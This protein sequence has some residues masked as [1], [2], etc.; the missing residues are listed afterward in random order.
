[1]RRWLHRTPFLLALLYCAAVPALW[2]RSFAHH[3]T[4]GRAWNSD[5]DGLW[6]EHRAELTSAGGIVQ[7]KRSATVKYKDSDDHL[8]RRDW[9][10]REFYVEHAPFDPLIDAGP[11]LRTIDA[12]SIGST[13]LRGDG[14]VV[15]GGWMT[16]ASGPVWLLLVPG[17]LVAAFTLGLAFGA[18]QPWRWR[19]A[20]WHA[21]LT[22]PPLLLVGAA[23]LWVTSWR[24]GYVW[25]RQA[26][27]SSIGQTT[28]KGT[29]VV[30]SRG[31]FLVAR[32][33]AKQA[34]VQLVA[35][36]PAPSTT[37]VGFYAPDPPPSPAAMFPTAPT[38]DRFGFTYTPPGKVG[39]AAAGTT[40]TVVTA[41]LWAFPVAVTPLVGWSA[42]QVRRAR[43]RAGRLRRGECVRCGY[44]LRAT[45]GRCPECGNDDGARGPPV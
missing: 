6:I 27:L 40:V 22:T 43:R 13:W 45:P 26:Q 32:N 5:G 24:A 36:Q 44:D 39:G 10:E 34:R 25:E 12:I 23:A 15:P 29:T 38:F 30:A 2:V 20:L 19:L 21:A 7:W 37:R 1:M 9:T 16:G 17:V 18:T 11:R 3:D 14:S 31:V 35:G 41:P 33:H 42:W 4:V 8:R 28:L